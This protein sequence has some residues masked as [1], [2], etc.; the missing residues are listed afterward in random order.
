MA[1]ALLSNFLDMNEKAAPGGKGRGRTRCSLLATD[2]QVKV[3]VVRLDVASC[4]SDIGRSELAILLSGSG[5]LLWK[6]VR[7]F[8]LPSHFSMQFPK[9]T[10]SAIEKHR[11][12]VSYSE[13]K[14]S[15]VPNN[16][17]PQPARAPVAR[18]DPPVNFAKLASCFSVS[19]NGITA[20]LLIRATLVC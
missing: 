17:E 6:T 12:F 19:L 18:A 9:P 3:C 7:H 2:A 5:R 10:R 11:G 16:P 20:T 1:S 8:L 13:M 15:I 4:C 14:C